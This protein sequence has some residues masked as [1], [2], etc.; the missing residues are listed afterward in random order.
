MRIRRVNFS[1]AGH[2]RRSNKQIMTII[3]GSGIVS[4]TKE[5][6]SLPRHSFRCRSSRG[7]AFPGESARHMSILPGQESEPS[8]V[9]APD[10]RGGPG[11]HQHNTVDAYGS[12]NLL[13]QDKYSVGAP[14]SPQ[15]GPAIPNPVGFTD[16]LI[17][18]PAPV[19]TQWWGAMLAR[20]EV[21]GDQGRPC[22]FWRQP[23]AS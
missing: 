6:F 4:S 13:L 21:H 1:I 20:H 16:G 2:A 12:S 22:P 23:D 14:L 11:S 8:K 5:H 10:D 17:Q 19:V 9:Q 3:A 7:I 15:E 18:R